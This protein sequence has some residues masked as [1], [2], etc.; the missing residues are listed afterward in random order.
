MSTP[1][2]AISGWHLMSRIKMQN[3]KISALSL[4]CSIGLAG[5][6]T[7]PQVPNTMPPGITEQAASQAKRPATKAERI[8]IID[9]LKAQAL[10]PASVELKEA[11]SD[12]NDANPRGFCALARGNDAI[13]RLMPWAYVAGVLQEQEGKPTATHTH[14]GATGKSLCIT[15]NYF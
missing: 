15:M 6:A 9:S 4:L 12:A 1:K 2:F 13:G 11:W 7:A 5:C 8:A 10:V 14:A 3:K